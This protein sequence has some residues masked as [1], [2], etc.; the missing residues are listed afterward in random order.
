[1]RDVSLVGIMMFHFDAAISMMEDIIQHQL[2]DKDELYEILGYRAKESETT[3]EERL[4]KVL[5]GFLYSGQPGKVLEFSSELR[6]PD[7]KK[8]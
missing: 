5:Q 4:W 6:G 2:V 3:Q 8:D 7:V 1:M